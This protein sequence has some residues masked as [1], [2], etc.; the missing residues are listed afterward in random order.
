MRIM[1]IVH[2]PVGPVA[3]EI[4]DVVTIYLCMRDNDFLTGD[5]RVIYLW[6]SHSSKA[7]LIKRINPVLQNW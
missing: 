7:S 5:L 2:E 1:K 3:V 6:L 4:M